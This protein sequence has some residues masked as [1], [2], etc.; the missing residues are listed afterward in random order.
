M[1]F[2]VTDGRHEMTQKMNLYDYLYFYMLIKRITIKRAS[3]VHC[4]LRNIE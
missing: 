1:Y 3:N 4:T 2:L